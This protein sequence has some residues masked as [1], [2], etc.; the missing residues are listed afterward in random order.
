MRVWA[1]IR[2][3]PSA[4]ER[5]PVPR[6]G[7]E[8]SIRSTAYTNAIATRP[9]LP[10][11]PARVVPNASLLVP[12]LFSRSTG[13]LRGPSIHPYRWGCLCYTHHV[14]ITVVVTSGKCYPHVSI[15]LARRWQTAPL[16]VKHTIGYKSQQIERSLVTQLVAIT[17]VQPQSQ[18]S[19]YRNGSQPYC[20]L[21]A[22]VNKGAQ[23]AL[24]NK[25]QRQLEQRQFRSQPLLLPVCLSPL[26]PMSFAPY[27]SRTVVQYMARTSLRNC[28][29]ITVAAPSNGRAHPLHAVSQMGVV[30]VSC[31]PASDTDFSR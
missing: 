26:R 13:S 24:G 21:T 22:A 6:R 18:L 12:F 3:R 20:T 25:Q 1:G 16:L 8:A 14:L 10:P 5:Q 7:V 17:N 29:S 11:L 27:F 30:T 15:V 19:N 2:P 9:A 28:R 4:L 23:K 31:S